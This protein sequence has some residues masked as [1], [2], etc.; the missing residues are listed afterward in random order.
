MQKP[1]KRERPNRRTAV[2]P[3]T[4]SQTELPSKSPAV[5]GRANMASAEA[6]HLLAGW[7]MT[8]LTASMG[9]WIPELDRDPPAA[10][11][12]IAA[13]YLRRATVT[14]WSLGLRAAPEDVDRTA[15]FLVTKLLTIACRRGRM[16]PQQLP[17][18]TAVGLHEIDSSR[19]LHG[20]WPL[21]PL[22]HDAQPSPKEP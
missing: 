2:P 3:S 12:A 7:S 10:A 20:A 11:P 15:R 14:A 16:F 13:R 1:T 19:A 18:A 22:A 17:T 21:W 6:V 9:A 4:L 5:P 8:G